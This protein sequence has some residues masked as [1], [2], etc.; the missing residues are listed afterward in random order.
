MNKYPELRRRLTYI[1]PVLSIAVS[2]FIV[3]HEYWRRDHLRTELAIKQAE[4]K[5]LLQ[6]VPHSR[7]PSDSD[8][9]DHHD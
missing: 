9:H 5:L 6:R 4:F 7:Q 8:D 3:S 1:L 2:V